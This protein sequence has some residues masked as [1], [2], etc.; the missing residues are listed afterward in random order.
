MRSKSTKPET[1]TRPGR[2]RS[3]LVAGVFVSAALVMVARAVDLQVISKDFLQDQGQARH[4]RVVEIPAHRGMIV[5]RN[6][7][8]LAVS[9]PVASVWVNPQQLEDGI[10]KLPALADLLGWST[11]KLLTYLADRAEREFV[12]L[13]RQVTPELAA[14][15]EALDIP[16]VNL[17]REYKRFYPAAEVT[18]HLVGFTDIDDAGQEGLELAFNEW[19]SGEA[20]RKRVLRD[21]L[22]Q[23]IENIEELA[24]AEPGQQLRTSIDLRLQYLA[25]RELKAAVINS[26][27]KSGSIVVMNPQTGE[28]LAIANQPSYNPNNRAEL[29]SARYRNRAVTDLFEPGSYFKPFPLAAALESGAY[30]PLTPIKTS[31]GFFKVGGYAVQ[32]PLDYGTID[33]TTVLAKSV[34][35]GAS[36]IALSMEP[37]QIWSTLAKFGFGS[38]TGSGFPGEASGVLPH[39]QRWRDVTQATMAYG[40]GLSVTPLQMAEAYSIIANDGKRVPVSFLAVDEPEFSERVVSSQTARQMRQM[41]EAVVSAEGTGRRAAISGYRVA[42][43]TGTARK[44][45]AGGYANDRHIAA[46]AGM[47][48]AVNPR[49]VAVIVLDEPDESRY[50]GG[51]V[52]APV[53]S[54]VVSGALR[55]L[56]IPPDQESV[57]QGGALIAGRSS[58]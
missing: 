26:G 20:G 45:E 27:A 57:S 35:T 12:Y 42:G 39:W 40:Y 44:A 49:I 55:L 37:E 10:D 25:Y 54:N 52:A 22:G 1:V 28:V 43:K 23:V 9:T 14:E 6:G 47:A 31:P 29:D 58:Q 17:K 48:P 8:P 2:W 7:E 32:D 21:R 3:G 46:F 30:S 18:S 36:K 11:E 51:E 38:A 50:Y 5:D 53:F 13:E 24:P 33:V 16:G 34:N 4:L 41:L 56:N 19:L 15:V